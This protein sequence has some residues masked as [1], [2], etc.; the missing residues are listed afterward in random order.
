MS[1]PSTRPATQFDLLRALLL[2]SLFI[3]FAA[4]AVHL[5]Y[6]SFW[7]DEGIS[8]LRSAQPLDELLANMPVEHLPGY[9]V[10]LHFWLRII[11]E[12]D[13]G[14]RFLSLWPS[15]LAV[16]LIFRLAV[17][18][19]RVGRGHERGVAAWC[20]LA[21]VALLATSMF[22]VWYAQELR[23]YSWL[24]T[25]SL[26][27]SWLLWRMLYLSDLQPWRYVAGYTAAVAVTV[28]LHYYG[29]LVPLAHTLFVLGWGV[30]TRRWRVLGRW[31][32]AGLAVLLLFLPWAQRAVG[33]VGF[34]GWRDPENPAMIPWHYLTAYTVGDAMPEPGRSWLPLLYLALLVL[35]LFFWWR[36]KPGGSLFLLANLF[37]PLGAVM[38]LAYRNPDFHPRY[39]IAL[40]GPLM[41]LV[42]GGIAGLNPRLWPEVSAGRDERWAPAVSVALLL[43]LLASN[44]VALGKLSVDTTLHKPDFRGAAWRIERE[45]QPDEVILVDG[46]D[47]EK[48]FL[49]YYDGPNTVHDLR[50][51]LE[52]NDRDVDAYLS[53][54]TAGADYA[55]EVLYF[56]APGP[57][58]VWLATRGWASA[59]S[60]H[61]DIRVVKYGLPGAPMQ[62]T[63]IG[64]AFGPAL[65]L[66]SAEVSVGPLRAGDL[67]RVSTHWFTNEEPSTFKFSLRLVDDAGDVVLARDYVPQNGF[68]P[69]DAWLVERPA[70]DRRGIL[71][72]AALAPGRYGVTLRLYDPVTGTAVE[73]VQGQDVTLGTIEVQ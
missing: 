1:R 67:L 55:W 49:H 8:L 36:V 23:M 26:L 60:D 73:T 20:G 28:Y 12:H 40:T 62:R 33:V 47:P 41:L 3:A 9:F 21:G 6:Q 42:A 29:F 18:M 11:G 19:G 4:R 25:A 71:L 5:D 50:I 2:V 56:H 7:S 68:A 15:V 72:P 65:T 14:L 63:Q 59:P 48:V 45:E 66:E 31:I 27:A 17:D 57:V 64:V 53:E 51:L 10:L 69:T 35:G 39:A 54:A 30:A 52:A 22:Q 38:A 37:V 24:L 61:N 32:G 70:T 16:A 58:Q 46:P 43:L 13:Y 34:S 44:V